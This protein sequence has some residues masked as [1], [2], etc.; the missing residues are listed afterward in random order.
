MTMGSDRHL[1][2]LA[3]E[4][5][6]LPHTDAYTASTRVGCVNH[7]TDGLGATSMRSPIPI[8][9]HTSKRKVYALEGVY[10]TFVLT[11]YPGEPATCLTR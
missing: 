2:V 10:L 9:N 4:S 6:L 3:Q 11:G 7:M 5:A 8:L 1:D